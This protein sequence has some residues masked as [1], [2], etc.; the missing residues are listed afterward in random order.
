MLMSTW[1]AVCDD[2]M[3]SAR[4]LNGYRQLLSGLSLLVKMKFPKVYQQFICFTGVELETVEL[5]QSAKLSTTRW[6]SVMFP[7]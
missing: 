4:A 3:A 7:P 5:T 1:Q 6:Y 2:C